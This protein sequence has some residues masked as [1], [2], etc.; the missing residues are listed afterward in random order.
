MAGL[1]GDLRGRVAVVTGGGSGIGRAIALALAAEGVDLVLA[2]VD[3]AA[4][5][6]VADEVRAEGVRAHPTRC[7][8]TDADAVDALA[9]EAWGEMGAV[10]LLVNNAGVV[11]SSNLLDTTPD[12]WDWVMGVNAR[13][14]YL[15]MRAFG[16]RFVAQ[17]TPSRILTTGSEHSLGVPHPSS[18]IYTASK[19]AV[20]ALSDVLR[21][22][23]PEH[24]GVSV[25]CPGLVRTRLWEAD[26]NRDPDDEAGLSAPPE[27][28]ALLFEEGLEAEELG[29]R[30][31]EGVKRGDFLI[32]THAHSARFAE[33][34]AE[35]VAAAFA[36]QAPPGEDD[37]RYDIE[38]VALRLLAEAEGP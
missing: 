38:Q 14:A 13:G 27:M 1:Q 29:R 18:A 32:V 12:D 26:R 35:E 6:A 9:D 5:T 7:D 20:L 30:A 17:E 36:A 8:V 24:V 4:A 21:R 22:E 15:A 31:V 2:D 37:D 28:L 23:V 34:R 10:D 33:A 3:D 16:R 25:L 19:H 11:H